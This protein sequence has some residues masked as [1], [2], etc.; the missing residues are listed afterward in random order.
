MDLTEADTR[1]LVTAMSHHLE[2]VELLSGV[3]LDLEALAA[4]DGLGRCSAL[5]VERDTVTR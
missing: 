3:T 2:K 5:E 4:Y 1:A